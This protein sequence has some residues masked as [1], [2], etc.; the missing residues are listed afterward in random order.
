MKCA[1]A[2][3]FGG[4]SK[5]T[6]SLH[7]SKAVRVLVIIIKWLIYVKLAHTEGPIDCWFRILKHI[8]Y[9]RFVV[10]LLWCQ[11]LTTP[12]KEA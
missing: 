12:M 4:E 9:A 11:F 3:P 2:L 1:I 8:A 6:I 5:R 7:S 10:L